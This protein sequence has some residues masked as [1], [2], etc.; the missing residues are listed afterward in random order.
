MRCDTSLLDRLRR[1][2]LLRAE[3]GNPANRLRYADLAQSL[4]DNANHLRGTSGLKQW[5]SIA[6]WTGWYPSPFPLT[7]DR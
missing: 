6:A 1:A 5:R 2:A 3:T 7:N 4:A